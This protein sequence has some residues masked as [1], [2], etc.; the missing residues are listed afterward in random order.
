MKTLERNI[1]I[2]RNIHR[3][4]HSF[5]FLNPTALAYDHAKIID[6]LILI[7]L[8]ITILFPLFPNSL[9]NSEV[10]NT[11]PKWIFGGVITIFESKKETNGKPPSLQIEAALN[12]RSCSSDSPIPLLLSR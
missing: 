1:F 3:L 9:T 6:I 10:R 5:T 7:P 8:R 12:R 4:L 11:S 2:H